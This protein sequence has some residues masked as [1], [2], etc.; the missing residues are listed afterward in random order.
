MRA[1]RATGRPLNSR[2]RGE[3]RQAGQGR[4][5]LEKQQCWRRVRKPGPM[6][7]TLLRLCPQSQGLSGGPSAQAPSSH[8]SCHSALDVSPLCPLLPTLPSSDFSLPLPSPIFPTAS[9]PYLVPPDFVSPFMEMGRTWGCSLASPWQGERGLGSFHPLAWLLQEG[10][11][12]AGE[13]P[14]PSMSVG[15]PGGWS[16]VLLR[17]EQYCRASSARRQGKTGECCQSPGG[18]S[19]ARLGG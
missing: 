19:E 14:V 4:V 8:F 6:R 12:G 1:T 18:C 10:R 2:S 9:S 7:L 13:G 5:H 16:W 15:V 17:A 3:A 11:Q